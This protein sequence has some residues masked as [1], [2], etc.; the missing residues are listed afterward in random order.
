MSYPPFHSTR[1]GQQ[2][3]DATLPSLLRELVRLNQN[4]EHLVDALRSGASQSPTG[5]AGE[6]RERSR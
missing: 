3:F 6:E 1:M 4:I 2:F 5:A